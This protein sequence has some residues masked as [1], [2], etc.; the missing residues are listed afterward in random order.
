MGATR[1]RG[2]GGIVLFLGI[3]LIVGIPIVAVTWNAVNEVATGDLRRLVIA[4]PMLVLLVAFLFF[5]GR[6]VHR[7][8][9]RG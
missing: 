1:E 5:F 6:H 9:S 4:V 3:Y 8:A 2:A 7:F